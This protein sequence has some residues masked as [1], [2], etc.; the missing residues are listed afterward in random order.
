MSEQQEEPIREPVQMPVKMDK[1]VP[2]NDRFQ[3]VIGVR[4]ADGGA[5]VEFK[6]ALPGVPDVR[7]KIQ[8]VSGVRGSERF[9]KRIEHA[10]KGMVIE[11]LYSV[12]SLP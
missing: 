9:M 12:A 7:E 4:L 1:Y 5:I 11:H 8:L 3:M 6:G 2:P 10:A